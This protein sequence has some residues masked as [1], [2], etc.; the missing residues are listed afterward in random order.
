MCSEGGVKA[1]D[2]IFVHGSFYSG[3]PLRSASL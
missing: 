3:G 2:V 1:V